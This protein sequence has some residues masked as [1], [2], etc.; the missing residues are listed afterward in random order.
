LR[1]MATATCMM[2]APKSTIAR[3]RI[4]TASIDAMRS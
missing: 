1:Y 3:W 2:A 4:M